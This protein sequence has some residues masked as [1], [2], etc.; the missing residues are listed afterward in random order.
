MSIGEGKRE[1]TDEEGEVGAARVEAAAEAEAAAEEAEA[2]AN[3]E[4]IVDQIDMR[5]GADLCK[6]ALLPHL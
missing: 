3:R 2:E 1:S 4:W 5:T 6:V